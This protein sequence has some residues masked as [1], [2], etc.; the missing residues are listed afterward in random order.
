MLGITALLITYN[1]RENIDRT[2][3]AISFVEK[4]IIVDSFSTDDTI[5]RALGI[6]P[7]ATVL[8]REFDTFAD[9]CNFGLTHVKTPWVLS[10]DADYVLTPELV[11][12]IKA[13]ERDPVVKAYRAGFR[14]CIFGHPLRS[15][16]YPPR[17]L[18]YRHE[19]AH[20]RNEGHGH[21]VSVD[22][23]VESLRGKIDHDDRKPLSRWIVSQDRYAIVEASH[24]LAAQPRELNAIDRLRRRVF[25]APPAIVLYLLFG[26]GLIFDGWRGWYYV[27]QRAIAE[28]LLSIRLLSARHH[29]ETPAVPPER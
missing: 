7:D 8:E 15:T 29:L 26:K 21:R 1:E 22:G 12:E 9:Q 18:L 25:F 16:I 13:L 14:Y 24:L 20:Y 23:A 5:A 28:M 27:C 3:R 17:T 6:R 4:L 19:A 11:E 2:V 10:L